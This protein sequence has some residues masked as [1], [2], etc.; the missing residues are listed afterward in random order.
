MERLADYSYSTLIGAAF[1]VIPSTIKKMLYYTHF[2]TGTNPI[3]AG[4]HNYINCDDGR[5]YCNTGH[6]VTPES[7]FILPLALRHPTI[8]LPTLIPVYHVVHELG[9]ALDYILG[10]LHI[11]RPVSDYAKTNREEAFA[12]AFTSWLFWGYG[13]QP[14]TSTLTLFESL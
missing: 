8:V 3:K 13:E 2:L 1:D 11:A 14:D 4:L 10:G 5:F 7:Q 12:E 9:H 6:F